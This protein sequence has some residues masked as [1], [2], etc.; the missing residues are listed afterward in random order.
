MN[1]FMKNK[2]YSKYKRI[3]SVQFNVITHFIR[4]KHTNSFTLHSFIKRRNMDIWIEKGKKNKKKRIHS[5]FINIQF[6]NYLDYGR[7]NNIKNS[8]LCYIQIK[9]QNTS[10]II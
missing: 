5:H 4:F 3:I 7:L 9:K 10:N 1:I 8:W 6:N 2:L